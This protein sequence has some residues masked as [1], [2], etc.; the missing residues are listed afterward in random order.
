MSKN[1]STALVLF[2]ALCLNANAYMVSF[3]V[4]E[5][6]VADNIVNS[7][8][9]MNW[10]SAFMD[11]FF[12]AGYIVSN[13]PALRM[14]TRPE[15]I[16]H[17]ASYEFDDALN[18][19]V[20]Y[21]FIVHLDYLQGSPSPGNITIHLYKMI[22]FIKLTERS[23]TARTYRSSREELDDYKSIVGGFIPLIN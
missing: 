3:F 1:L 21:M 23:M 20:D 19:G 14:R 2:F 12:D 13:A 7:E 11:V 5:T 9:S 18:G 22:P 10:E 4:L 16:E 17:A 15:S 6:G 8:H